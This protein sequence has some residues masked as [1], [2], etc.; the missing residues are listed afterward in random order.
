MKRFYSNGLIGN[1]MGNFQKHHSA[2]IEK[3]MGRNPTLNPIE[4]IKKNQ[5][6]VLDVLK[7]FGFWDAFE[8][9]R[10]IES[11]RKCTKNE[12][13]TTRVIMSKSDSESGTL[14][15]S[16]NEDRIEELKNAMYFLNVPFI[17]KFKE[18][19]GGANYKQLLNGKLQYTYVITL[20]KTSEKTLKSL[21][22]DGYDMI[23]T[24]FSSDS[25]AG[26]ADLRATM[27]ICNNGQVVKSRDIYQSNIDSG[28]A[29]SFLNN[30]ADP[31]RGYFLVE[32]H[33]PDM[34]EGS[35]KLVELSTFELFD[36]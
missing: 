23:L 2:E 22:T 13:G 10:F 8:C 34:V 31:Q 19:D 24:D 18:T 36:L 11:V 29:E 16:C 3:V 9:D 27:Q 6:D 7:G 33:R 17:A 28:N 15:F 1:L 32:R 30:N 26:V 14:I 35:V 20:R 21:Y 5:R 25:V 12:D 4:E